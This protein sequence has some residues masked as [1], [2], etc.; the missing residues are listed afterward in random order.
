M[1]N[2]KIDRLNKR[3]VTL[4]KRISKDQKALKRAN[5]E[6]QEEID[7]NK[8]KKIDELILYFND[9]NIDISLDELVNRIKNDDFDLK[10]QLLANIKENNINS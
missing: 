10:N 4:E 2:P 5:D 6:L 7:K 9:L 3:I 8:I 1:A